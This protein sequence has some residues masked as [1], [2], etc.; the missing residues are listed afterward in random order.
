[1]HQNEYK[2]AY[3]WSSGS[4]DSL[5]YFDKQDIFFPLKHV[6]RMKSINILYTLAL[7]LEYDWNDC[8]IY[9]VS[10]AHKVKAIKRY[11]QFCKW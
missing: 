8:F 6:V 5:W 7:G 11:R 9:V 2:Q 1:M 10:A 4:W 3:V